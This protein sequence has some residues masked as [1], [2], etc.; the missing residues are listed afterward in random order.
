MSDY[1]YIYIYKKYSFCF[2][3]FKMLDEH[4]FDIVDIAVVEKDI[5]KGKQNF[6]KLFCSTYFPNEPF[7]CK[8]P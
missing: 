7:L 5:A 8:L 3:C 4:E 6:L 2:V 1:I